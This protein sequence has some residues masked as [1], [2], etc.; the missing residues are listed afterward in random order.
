MEA[1]PAAVA[2]GCRRG[3]MPVRRPGSSDF[4]AVRVETKRPR[5]MGGPERPGPRPEASS[6]RWRPAPAADST[7]SISLC[8]HSLEREAHLRSAISLYFVVGVPWSNFTTAPAPV[9]AKL[10][11][12]RHAS[13]GYSARVD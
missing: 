6:Q 8:F 7:L 1:R 11:L 13:T 4:A 3:R 9:P 5:R 12:S 2:A 10:L